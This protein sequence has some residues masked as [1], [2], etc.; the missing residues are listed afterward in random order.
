MGPLRT[1]TFGFLGI[2]IGFA[3]AGLVQNPW[4]ALGAIAVAGSCYLSTSS[5][6]TT[7]LQEELDDDVRGRV[8]A[9]WAIGF[10]GARP[11]A[12][13]LD[14]AVADA[15]SPQLAILVMAGLMALTFSLI[16]VSRLRR[17]L[18]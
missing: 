9:L 16:A 11:F 8:M 14:G 5:D 4:V 7:S 2:G 15:L 10:L 3:V 17:V 12:A 6:I 13:L 18:D 1:A